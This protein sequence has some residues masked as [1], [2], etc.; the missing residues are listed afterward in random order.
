MVRDINELPPGHLS[1]VV[2]LQLSCPALAGATI[3]NQ[4]PDQPDYDAGQYDAVHPDYDPG[5]GVRNSRPGHGADCSQ[6]QRIF[7]WSPS[8]GE[9]PQK[10]I[11]RY[12]KNFL[13]DIQGVTL[14][15]AAPEEHQL[16][17]QWGNEL[18]NPHDVAISRFAFHCLQLTAFR[19]YVVKCSWLLLQVWRCR[20]CG[21]NWTKQTSQVWGLSLW[22]KCATTTTD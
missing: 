10:I 3:P 6:R 9:I 13:N 15:L 16:V 12:G 1:S 8:Q 11:F 5:Q 22:Q 21:R 19:L 20:L 7:L 2:S 17:G 14:D 18:Q 4:C